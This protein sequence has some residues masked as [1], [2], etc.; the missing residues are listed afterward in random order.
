MH[1]L[2]VIIPSGAGGLVQGLF[3]WRYRQDVAIKLVLIC[4][5]LFLKQSRPPG[6][7]SISFCCSAQPALSALN[8]PESCVIGTMRHVAAVAKGR[9]D[10]HLLTQ[11]FFFSL[12]CDPAPSGLPGSSFSVVMFMHACHRHDPTQRTSATEALQHSFFSLE[13]ELPTGAGTAL[14]PGPAAAGAGTTIAGAAPSRASSRDICQ[15]APAVGASTAAVAPA[16][17]A[18]LPCPAAAVALASQSS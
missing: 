18:L 11:E 7:A 15:R 12:K 14:Q 6:P 5:E 13:L 16:A 4:V 8:E 17:D 9:F 2:N 3:G 1:L 10:H